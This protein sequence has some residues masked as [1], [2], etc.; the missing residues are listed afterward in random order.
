MCIG[1]SVHTLQLILE[2]P[3]N[4]CLCFAIEVE[5]FFERAANL[6]LIRLKFIK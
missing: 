2:E 1:L 3:R 4:L 5:F 6:D